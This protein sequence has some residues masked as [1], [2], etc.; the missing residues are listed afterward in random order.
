[1]C[2][3]LGEHNRFDDILL[4]RSWAWELLEE[5]RLQEALNIILSITEGSPP[6]SNLE[7]PSRNSVDSAKISPTALLKAR[8]VRLFCSYDFLQCLLNLLDT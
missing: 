5:D 1:M 6:K 3:T 2:D 4:W 8:K 7:S